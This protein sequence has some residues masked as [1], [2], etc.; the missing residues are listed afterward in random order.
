M[1]AAPGSK[2]QAVIRARLD[3]YE[4]GVRRGDEFPALP[5]LAPADSSM[6]LIARALWR[7]IDTL[8]PFRVA[9]SITSLA[10]AFRLRRRWAAATIAAR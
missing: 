10:Q 7:P 9:R 3:R 1:Y 8:Y 4:A 6:Q 5:P 2:T